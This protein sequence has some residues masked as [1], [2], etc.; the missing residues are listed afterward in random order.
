MCHPCNVKLVA[1][2]WEEYRKLKQR[3][4]WARLKALRDHKLYKE[5]PRI[6]QLHAWLMKNPPPGYPYRCEWCLH[7]TWNERRECAACW[8]Y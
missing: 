4:L 2:L 3:A 1:S 5:P 7:G 8:A 6:Q